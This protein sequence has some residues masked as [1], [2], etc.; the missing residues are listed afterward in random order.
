MAIK[1]S[2]IEKGQ[3]GVTGGKSKKYYASTQAM[4]EINIRELTALIEERS[5]L[6][7]PVVLSTL[8]VL[9]EVLIEKLRE[10]YIVRLDELGS[11]RI[12]ISSAAAAKPQE[13]TDKTIKKARVL[14]HPSPQLKQMLKSLTFKK[15]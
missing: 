1:F 15:Q 11:F 5:T 14:F 9:V 12:S 13:V 3:P 2:V 8:W 6:N 7:S 10:G 4:G